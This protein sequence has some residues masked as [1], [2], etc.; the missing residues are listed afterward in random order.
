M[1]YNQIN[2]LA[3]KRSITKD[4]RILIKNSELSEAGKFLIRTFCRFDKYYKEDIPGI[5]L[6]IKEMNDEIRKTQEAYPDDRSTDTG[7][8]VEMK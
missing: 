4:E 5:S 2:F 6:M 8:D 3:D 7:T 1:K